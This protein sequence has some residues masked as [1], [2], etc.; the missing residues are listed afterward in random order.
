[1]TLLE[2]TQCRSCNASPRTRDETAVQNVAERES[3]Y[4]SASIPVSSG[5]AAQRADSEERSCERVL[6]HS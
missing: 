3:S 2:H 5:T 1:M 4:A 6:L